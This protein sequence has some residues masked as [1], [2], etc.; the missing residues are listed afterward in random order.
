MDEFTDIDPVT[1]V[2][3]WSPKRTPEHL[4]DEAKRSVRGQS[5]DTRICVVEDIYQ[6]GPSWA[7]NQGIDEADTRYIA[8]L[9]AD[10]KWKKNKLSRQLS[11]MQH[12]GA[13]ICIQGA[14]QSYEE[15][16]KGILSGKIQSITSSI[17]IDTQKV[18][19]RFD[20]NLV[21]YEDH[22]FVLEA[23]TQGDVCF[24]QD[25]IMV[26]KQDDGLSS[27]TSPKLHD[28][29]GEAYVQAIKERVPP[30]TPF[31]GL[32]YRRHLYTQGRLYHFEE[33]YREAIDKFIQSMRYGIMIRTL[34]ALMLSSWRYIR[35]SFH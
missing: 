34:F 23:V 11:K 16:I 17:V 8:F 10:D 27:S 30:A 9:D 5:V 22:L 33:L 7:R 35:Q 3:P 28:K 13:G 14:S 2:I 1:V 15:F 19:V 6:H 20:E 31:L 4:L 24:C 29:M 25:L 21:R 32:F 12:S 26:R 18:Q